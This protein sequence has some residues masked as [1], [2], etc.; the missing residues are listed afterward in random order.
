MGIM[1]AITFTTLTIAVQFAYAV[2]PGPAEHGPPAWAASNPN[3]TLPP[4]QTP[5]HYPPDPCDGASVCIPPGLA[6]RV[7]PPP[8]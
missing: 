5:P 1:L 4:G 7:A 2:P 8:S 6:G 3:P